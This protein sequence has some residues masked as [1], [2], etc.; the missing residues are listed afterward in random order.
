MTVIFFSSKIQDYLISLP[1]LSSAKSFRHI[2]LLQVFGNK[3]EMPYSKQILPNLYELRVRGQQ[4]VRIFYCFH[5]NQAVVLHAFIKKSQKTPQK[6]I[7]IALKRI[8]LLT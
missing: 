1:K 4:E 3:L 7:Q 6:E 5:K 2:R 8:R